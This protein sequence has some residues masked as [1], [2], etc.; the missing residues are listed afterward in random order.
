MRT[1]TCLAIFL[2]LFLSIT[3]LSQTKLNEAKAAI[4]SKFP[5]ESYYALKETETYSFAVN[6]SG[7]LEVFENFR[8]TLFTN[9]HSYAKYNTVFYDDYSKVSNVKYAENNYVNKDLQVI[10]TNYEKEEIFHDDLKLCAYKM[11]MEK[12]KVYDTYYTKTY[13]NPRFFTKV[14]FHSDYPIAEKVIKFDVPNWLTI[15]IKEINFEGYRVVKTETISAS[16]K[17]KEITYTINDAISIPNEPHAPGISKYMP[18]LLVFI[19]SFAKDKFSESFFTGHKDVYNWNKKLASEVENKSSDVV[20]V[21]HD[22]IRNETDSLKQIEKVFY[23]VQDNIRYIAFEDGIMGYKP[24]NAGKVCNLLYGDCKGMANLTKTFLTTLGFDAR[25]TWI[26][27]NSIPYNNDLPTL[28]VY[29]HMICAVFFRGKIYF[30]DGTEDYIAIGDYAERIQSRPCMIENGDNYII[31][32]I[33]GFS[34]ER[35]LQQETYTLSIE[36]DRLKGSSENE[37]KGETKTTFLRGYNQTKTINKENAL[38]K[39]LASDNR[40]LSIKNI[41]T[42]DLN[43]RALPLKINFDFEISNSVLKASN[44]DLV[45]LLNKDKYLKGLYFDSTRVCDYEFNSKYYITTSAYLN[46]PANYK[47][48]SLPAP[49]SIDNDMFSFK[50]NYETRDG[51]VVLNKVIKV[52]KGIL[53]KPDFSVW[54][55]SIKE[56]I[57]FYNSPVILS[58]I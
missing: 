16:K 46:L 49:V 34:Y 53:T 50:L 58:K 9:E 7:K 37:F 45:V 36:G 52:K 28:A 14:F 15:E 41:K 39:Y 4:A 5:D 32:K 43:E 3:L 26:G 8:S 11:D 2:G 55:T 42:S 25:L 57:N 20:T 18:H 30:L 22:I 12:G 56:V 24:A 54:N 38:T 19:K 13:L 10:Y 27:T 48:K 29:N 21:L 23:W 51:K 31:E 17:S 6:K 44:N 47:A 40:D 33:P 35:N 1:K